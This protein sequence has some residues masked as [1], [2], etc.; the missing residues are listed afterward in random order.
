MFPAASAGASL[1]AVWM[2]G[3]LKGMIAA[4]TPLGSYQVVV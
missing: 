2:G 4:V 1:P 3:Q